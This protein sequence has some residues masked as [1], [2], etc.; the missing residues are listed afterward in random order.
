MQEEDALTHAPQRRRAEFVRASLSLR[1]IVREPLAHMMH[2]QIR[3]V[4]D[5]PVL[6]NGLFMTGAVCI[7]GV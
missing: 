5:W 4:V 2:E 1:D 6:K 3:V 7:C